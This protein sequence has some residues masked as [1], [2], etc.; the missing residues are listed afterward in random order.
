VSPS[1]AFAFAGA[2]L[3]SVRANGRAIKFQ[4]VLH[5][6]Q[7]ETKAS[8]QSNNPHENYIPDIQLLDLH[9]FVPRLR[10]GG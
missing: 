1:S 9:N 10:I 5:G 7:K 3:G 4:E 6:V 2:Q 8:H